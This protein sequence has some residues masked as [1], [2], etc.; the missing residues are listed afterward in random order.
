MYKAGFSFIALLVFILIP[1][2][3]LAQIDEEGFDLEAEEAEEDTKKEEI[4][5]GVRMWYLTG[6]GA[7]QDSTKLDTLQDYFHIYHPVYKDIITATFLGNYGNPAIDNNYFGRDYNSSYFFMQSREAYLYSPSELEYYNTRTPYTRFDF[8]QSENKSKNNETRFDVIHSQNI[9]PYWNF[10]FRTNMEKSQGQYVSQ[11]SKNKMV[12]LY[13]SYNKDN[14]NVYGGFLYSSVQNEENGGLVADSLLNED[15][16]PEYWAVNL[17]ESESKLSNTSYF[18]NA[19]YRLGKRIEYEDGDHDFIPTAG[20]IYSFQYDRNKHQFY[21]DEEDNSFWDNTYYGDE[22]KMDSIRF[23]RVRNIV[24]LKQYEHPDKKYTFGKRAYVGHEY[25]NGSMAEEYVENPVQMDY[26]IETFGLDLNGWEPDSIVLRS[27]IKYSNFFVG[28]GIFRE[29]GK[30]WNWNFDGKFYFAGRNAG[31][32]ELHGDISKPFTFLNDTTSSITFTG[33]IE[34]MVPDYFQDNFNSNHFQWSNNLDME[35]RMTV[36]ANFNMKDR[37]L[38]IG[39]NYAIVNNLLYNDTLGI[40]NQTKNEISVLSAYLDKDFVLKNFHFRTRIL[41]QKASNE[42]YLHLP[43]WSAF[44]STFY[45]FTVSKV[46]LT[47]IGADARYNTKYYA[48]A[49]AP[50]TGLFHLQNETQYGNYPYIDVYASVRLKRTRVFFK[51]VNVSTNFIDGV[52]MT[53]PHYPMNRSTFRLGVSWA[54]YD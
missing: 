21:E 27:D 32:V 44:V 46:L 29:T 2:F 24:Q 49:Y 51:W 34:N 11:D 5:P 10:A 39:A 8:S 40:P 38:E 45:Q 30:F 15:R 36:G 52:F 16:D 14:W 25:N 35:Q 42:E 33:A 43:E 28:G 18:M 3:S 50:S 9:S 37:R 26:P 13:T 41:W 12:A 22:Y 23:N 1:I 20:L 19:E 31:Q 48:D 6:E 53:A 7:F 4:P 54:F 17:T 47:Q